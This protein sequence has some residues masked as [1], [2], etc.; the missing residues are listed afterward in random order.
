MCGTILL[1]SIDM[2]VLWKHMWHYIIS[3]YYAQTL[4]V[5]IWQPDV[6]LHLAVL[7]LDLH[8]TKAYNSYKIYITVVYIEACSLIIPIYLYTFTVNYMYIL[9]SWTFWGLNWKFF[10]I[11]I[12]LKS[13]Y[14]SLFI[15]LSVWSP[16]TRYTVWNCLIM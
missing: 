2:N 10:Q 6:I 5:I 12:W 11:L 1:F 3:Y 4:L 7:L 15:F 8:N 14:F 9:S 16:Q 13:S